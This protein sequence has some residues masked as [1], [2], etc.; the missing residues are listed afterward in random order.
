MKVNKHTFTLPIQTAH[1]A[2]T[3]VKHSYKEKQLQSIKQLQNIIRGSRTY[4]LKTPNCIKGG[5][6]GMGRELL[7]L[8]ENLST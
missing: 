7:W 6:R 8:K 2:E 5:R 4:V 3:K 1:C